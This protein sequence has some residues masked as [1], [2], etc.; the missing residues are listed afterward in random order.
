MPPPARRIAVIALGTRGEVEP[1]LAMCLGLRAAGHAVTV[2]LGANFTGWAAAH[3][4]ASVPTVDIE[5]VMKS[6]RGMAWS[7][8]SDSPL[9]QL[10]QMGALFNQHAAAMYAA[11]AQAARSADLLVGGFTAEPLVQIAAEQARLPY[12][13]AFLQPALPTR[14]GAAALVPVVPRGISLLNRWTGHV[15]DRLLWSVA[16]RPVNRIRASLGR[17]P[18][19]A[20]GYVARRAA[21]PTLFG[22]SPRVVPPA[23]DWPAHAVA[24]GYWFFDEDAGWEPPP[25]LSAFLSAGPPP[26]Y[27]GFGSMS[28]SAPEATLR[29]IIAAA[30]HAGHRLV[31]GAGWSGLAAG[32]LPASVLCIP[33]APHAW[34]FP[35]VAAVVHHGG[36]GTTAAGLR[37]GR[38][39]L[40]IPHMSDQPYWGRRVHELGVGPRPIPR[41]TLTVGGLAAGLRRLAE[42]A[43]LRERAAALGSHIRAEAG[44]ARAVALIARLPD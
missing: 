23:P 15:A 9:R 28:S 18:Q 36:A 29:L 5:A 44:V 10:R 20:R 2:V 38:P 34:L 41:H 11:V 24:T 39:T 8:A 30:A 32:E 37:A 14:S 27:V 33:G 6:E 16:A 22:F 21:A 12:V 35:R 31:V 4:L 17:P 1:M 40:I 3:G 43:G 19:T 13:N 7:E 25:E 26:T 42:D